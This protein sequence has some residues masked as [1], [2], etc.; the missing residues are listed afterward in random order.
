MLGFT[1]PELLGSGHDLIE[2]LTNSDMVLGTIMFIL[3]GRFLFSSLSF[4]SGAPGGIFFPLLVIGGFIGGAVGEVCVQFFGLDPAYFNNFVLIAMAGYFSAIVRAPLTGII[5][6]FEMTG[7]LSQMLSLSTVSIVAYIVATLLGSK[8]IY[9]SL[10]ERL[11]EKHGEKA[12]GEEN[13]IK[14]KILSNFVVKKGSKPDGCLVKDVEW[15]DNCLIVSIQRGAKEIIPKGKTKL[16][17]GDIIVT[18]TDERDMA[19]IHE[20]ME[21]LCRGF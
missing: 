1:A 18:M 9:E 20:K 4:G 21:E 17:A 14:Q 2:Q 13:N 15:P 3:V 12:S 10:L 19:V 16:L 5:L 11:M 8:P 7:T 6:I